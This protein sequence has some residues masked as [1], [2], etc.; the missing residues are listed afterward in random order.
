M[1]PKF[2]CWYCGR[3]VYYNSCYGS[4][5]FSGEVYLR[6]TGEAFCLTINFCSEKCFDAFQ[7]EGGSDES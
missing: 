4:V 7:K 3:E 6:R 5:R 1:E 2:K